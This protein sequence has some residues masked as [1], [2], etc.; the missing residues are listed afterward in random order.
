MMGFNKKRRD[1]KRS[2]RCYASNVQAQFD[3]TSITYAANPYEAKR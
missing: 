1:W 2:K 3:Q